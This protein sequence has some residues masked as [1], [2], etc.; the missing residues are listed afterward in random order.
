[1]FVSDNKKMQLFFFETAEWDMQA[2]ISVSL[3]TLPMRNIK[4]L[5]RYIQTPY[6]LKKSS[7]YIFGSL[8]SMFNS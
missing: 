8:I 7:F 6:C 5:T 1:M 3:K 4:K 2:K